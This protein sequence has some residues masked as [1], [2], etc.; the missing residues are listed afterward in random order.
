MRNRVVRLPCFVYIATHRLVDRQFP[1]RS[2]VVTTVGYR[3]G[4]RANATSAF[5]DSTRCFQSIKTESS[6]GLLPC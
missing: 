5:C 6:S 3:P 1:Y 2:I 4:K